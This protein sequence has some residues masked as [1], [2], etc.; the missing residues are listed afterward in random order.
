MSKR[1][2]ALLPDQEMAEIQR[3]ARRERLTVR[4]WVRDILRDAR[5]QRPSNDPEGKLKA[6]RR[7]SNSRSQLRI[8]SR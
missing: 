5:E 8:L 6:I 4:E 1:Q 3:L 2:Q 7:A